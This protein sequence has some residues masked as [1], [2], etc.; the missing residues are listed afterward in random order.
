M[1]SSLLLLLLSVAPGEAPPLVG[2]LNP[3]QAQSSHRVAQAITDD[4]PALPS[5]EAIPPGEATPS[6]SPSPSS[7]PMMSMPPSTSPLPAPMSSTMPMSAP[8][9]SYGPPPGAVTG[10]VADA[11]YVEGPMD[12]GGCCNVSCCGHGCGFRLFGCCHSPQYTAAKWHLTTGDMYPY[13]PYFPVYHGNYYFRP[14]YWAHVFRDQEI[15]ARWGADP[16]SP[17]T[18]NVFDQVYMDFGIPEP[19]HLEEVPL[20]RDH[21]RPSSHFDG[22]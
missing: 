10:P 1:Q 13:T 12:G 16:T 21:A 17:Y 20:P 11:G 7:A 8:P 2:P 15:A 5:M 19:R 22:I 6:Y 3:W 4:A 9:M 18:S 14:Y